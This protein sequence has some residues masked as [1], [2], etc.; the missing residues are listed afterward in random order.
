MAWAGS[1]GKVRISKLDSPN[2]EIT[3]VKQEDTAKVTKGTVCTEQKVGGV[4]VGR[5]WAEMSQLAWTP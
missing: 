1:C 2:P 3:E 4:G 5:A